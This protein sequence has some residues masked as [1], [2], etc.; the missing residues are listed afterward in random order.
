MNYTDAS[1][2]LT[3]HSYTVLHILAIMI[4]DQ[5][6]YLSFGLYHLARLFSKHAFS[7]GKYILK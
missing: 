7:I 5:P 2:S 3:Y 1:L 6:Q 4:M